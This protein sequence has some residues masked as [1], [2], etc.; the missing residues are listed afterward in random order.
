MA[1]TL[2]FRA[3]MLSS[4]MTEWHVWFICYMYI[5][6]EFKV[7]YI[8][9]HPLFSLTTTILWGRFGWEILTEPKSVN[10]LHWLRVDLKLWFKF[11][12]IKPHIYSKHQVPFLTVWSTLWNRLK[13]F[14]K[15][16]VTDLFEIVTKRIQNVCGCFC[17]N[18]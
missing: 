15:N 14:F 4:N 18:L 8:A 1:I 16:Y 11:L 7:A 12:T 13:G 2:Q 17:A 5:F 9:L 10:Q 6:Y 3:I